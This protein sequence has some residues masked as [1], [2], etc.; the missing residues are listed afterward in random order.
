MKLFKLANIDVIK[1]CRSYFNFLL[2]SD[3]IAYR[4]SK[5]GAKFITCNN[6]LYYFG[7]S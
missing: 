6:L 1:E 4:K 2:P 5:F 3:M 7:L